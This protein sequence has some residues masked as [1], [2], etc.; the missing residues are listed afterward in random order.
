MSTEPEH[1]SSGH[2]PR[3]EKAGA[4]GDSSPRKKNSSQFLVPSPL[5]T[6]RNRTI[7]QSNAVSDAPVRTGVCKEF[8]RNKGHGFIIPDNKEFLPAGA[9]SELFVHISDITGELVPK[10]GDRVQFKTIACPPK[11]VDLQA[12]DVSIIE[13]HGPHET[14]MDY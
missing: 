7:S 8:C 9:R 6:R 5:P 11:K 3:E 4:R 12:V 13:V 14:W 2:K 1:K 10:S